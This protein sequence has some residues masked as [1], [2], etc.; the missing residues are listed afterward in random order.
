MSGSVVWHITHTIL[1]QSDRFYGQIADKPNHHNPSV[2]DAIRDTANGL[3]T[4]SVE[5]VW[6]EMS[7]ILTGNHAPHLIQ[8]MY[9][10]GVANAIG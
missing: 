8:L 10:L 2:L 9:Q 3:K 5:R 4:I 7:R 1:T 6:M